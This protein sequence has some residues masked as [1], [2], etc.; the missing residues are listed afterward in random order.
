MH[1]KQVKEVFGVALAEGLAEDGLLKLEENVRYGEEWRL[2]APFEGDLLY[3]NWLHSIAEAL[4]MH[5]SKVDGQNFWSRLCN[6]KI[7]IAEMDIKNKKKE[8]LKVWL[9]VGLKNNY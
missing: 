3:L 5:S 8:W 9:K 1:L 6:T 4:C 7:E 2:V